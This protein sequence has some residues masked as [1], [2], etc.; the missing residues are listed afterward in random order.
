MAGTK[1]LRGHYSVYAFFPEAVADWQNLSAAE[2]NDAIA[3][4]LGFDISCALTDDSVTINLTDS[5]TDDSISI[6]DIGNV[7][8]PTFFNYEVSFDS[9]R[10]GPVSSGAQVPVYEIPVNL[11]ST[12]DRPFYIV[13]RIGPDQGTAFAAGQEVS[14]YGVNTDYPTDVL[15]DGDNILFGSR[16][17]PNGQ[18]Y[19]NAEL[20]A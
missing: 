16:F 8:T 9:F 11:F 13:K 17:K 12:A 2:L 6:C 1:L 7:S 14:V 19:T 4:G 3:G 15:G 20:S 5:D 18:V 10:N